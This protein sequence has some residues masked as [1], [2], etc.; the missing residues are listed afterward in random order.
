MAVDRK[1]DEI[2]SELEAKGWRREG[3]LLRRFP[4]SA[5]DDEF[6]KGMFLAAVSVRDSKRAEK[7][8][9][10]LVALAPENPFAYLALSLVKLRQ[11]KIHEAAR[12][13]DRAC[14]FA[15]TFPI[16][17]SQKIHWLCLQG[18]LEEAEK[19]LKETLKEFSDRWEVQ[20]AQAHLWILG[21]QS[22]HW[23]NRAV[24]LLIK[25][26]SRQPSDPIT[27]ALL[28]QAFFKL[29]DR[30][31]AIE[32][33][34]LMA[35]QLPILNFTD[36]E[37][38]I[39]HQI[40]KQSLAMNFF[41]LRPSWLIERFLSRWLPPRYFIVVGILWLAVAFMLAALHPFAPAPVY[42]LTL[43]F[44]IAAFVYDRLAIPLMLW[45]LRSKS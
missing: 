20:R 24:E 36:F 7:I 35:K 31:R 41:L 10:N 13:F 19:V 4:R 38:F 2:A 40:A 6:V 29:G 26:V 28:A 8:A 15:S 39:A 21:K 11:G 22:H 1:F 5:W 17:R 18:K 27:H 14:H 42:T 23:L 25:I 3:E 43:S 45:W 32:Q 34:Q 30:S 44:A 16:Y 12:A 33:L 37:P 9:V